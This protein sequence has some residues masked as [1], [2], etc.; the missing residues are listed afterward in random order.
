LAEGATAGLSE[1][2]FGLI[3]AHN[4]FQRWVVHC[5]KA[6]GVAELGYLDILVLHNVNHRDRPKRLSDICFV[7]NVEDTHTVSYALRK[8]IRSGLA[9]GTRQGKE[10]VYRTTDAGQRFCRRYANARDRCLLRALDGMGGNQSTLADTADILRLL[11]GL[12]DQA[13]RAAA[14]L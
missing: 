11:S 14:S 3:V 9:A 10:T 8:L 2:E 5:A 12:Y 13:A 1:V 7:L 6:A 4:A